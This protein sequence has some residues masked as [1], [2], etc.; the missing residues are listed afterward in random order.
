MDVLGIAVQ[1][2][3]NSG[4]RMTLRILNCIYSTIENRFKGVG[5]RFISLSREQRRL[6]G[7]SRIRQGNGINWGAHIFVFSG[8]QPSD[9]V[10]PLPSSAFA[11]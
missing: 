4:I 6:D 9:S 7:Q 2:I 11:R 8:C 1:E 3:L 5:I 10:S